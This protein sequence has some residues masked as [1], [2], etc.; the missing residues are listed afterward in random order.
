L[1]GPPFDIAPTTA[2]AA[3]VT[4]LPPPL[5]EFAKSK[6]DLAKT[7]PCKV[8]LF[9]QN[10]PTGQ[11]AEHRVVVMT[12][13]DARDWL[14]QQANGPEGKNAIHRKVHADTMKKLAAKGWKPTGEVAVYRFQSTQPPT[15]AKAKAEPKTLAK[16]IYN[17]FFPTLHAEDTYY[18]DEGYIWEYDWD[19]GDNYTYEGE[20]G[21]Y[22]YYYGNSGDGAVQAHVDP[23]YNDGPMQRNLEDGFVQMSATTGATAYS[24]SFRAIL[25]CTAGAAF[26]GIGTCAYFGPWTF[27]CVVGR[28]GVAFFGCMLTQLAFHAADM[29]CAQNRYYC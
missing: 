12:G 17:Y 10:T 7:D 23:A 3:T 21:G 8:D 13:Q 1:C 5:P 14:A 9:Y 16:Q 6:R 26:V 19:D 15:L 11:S 22:E 24:G 27:Q 20:I 29:L 25:G 28:F 4:K 2:E 18:F